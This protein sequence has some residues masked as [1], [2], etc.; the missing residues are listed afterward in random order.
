MN[1]QQP[2]CNCH[3]AAGNLQPCPL[4]ADWADAMWR[5]AMTMRDRRRTIHDRVT[6]ASFYWM[7]IRRTNATRAKEPAW[8]VL[9]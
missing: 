2:D 3:E 9:A 1:E 7:C 8:S 6:L 5:R 4:H